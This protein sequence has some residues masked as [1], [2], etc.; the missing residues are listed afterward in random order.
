MRFAGER[1]Q[2]EK[3]AFAGPAAGARGGPGAFPAKRVPFP[4]GFAFPLPTAEGGAAVLANEAQVAF[5]HRESP[6]KTIL[7]AKMPVRTI[8]EHFLR[9]AYFSGGK[10]PV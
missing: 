4:A 6:D 5:R 8:Q 9:N 7:Q 2:G 1:L 10:V 3:T